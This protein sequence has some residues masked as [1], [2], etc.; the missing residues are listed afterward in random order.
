MFSPIEVLI[1][2]SYPI[3]ISFFITSGSPVLARK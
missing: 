3:L 2:E 1:E